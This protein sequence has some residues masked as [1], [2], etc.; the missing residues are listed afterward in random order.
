MHKHIGS[1]LVAAALAC[2]PTERSRGDVLLRKG[3]R[4]GAEALLRVTTFLNGV[5]ELIRTPSLLATATGFALFLLPLITML[6]LAVL[7]I[8]PPS[9]MAGLIAVAGV[10]TG[11]KSSGSDFVGLNDMLKNVYTRAFENN[12][13]K[14]QEVLDIIEKAEGFE[15]TEGADG[16]NV[17]MMHTFSSGGGVGAMDEDDYLYTPTSPTIKQ[18]TLAIKQL[19]ATV[20]LSGR[21]LRRVK[22]GPAAFATWAD[23][24]LPRKAQR[25]AFHKDRMALGTGTGIICRVDEA[26]PGTSDLGIDT[27][28]G[29]S[30]LEGAVNLLL[31]DD[32]LRW[33][34]NSN[35][36]S[37][38]TGAAI[39]ASVDYANNEIDIDAVPT[40]G[41]DNDYVFL[42][43]ANVNGSG[44]REMMGLEGIIDDGSN[45][46]T[47]QGL[48]R[49]T[50]P[51]LKSQI[52]DST[53]GSWGSELTEDI[54]DYADSLAWE[55]MGGKPSIILVNRSGQ[56]SFWKNLKNDRVINDPRGA[57]QGGK[58]TLNMILGDRTAKVRAA[59]KVPLSRAHLIDPSTIQRYKIGAGR[60]DDTDGSVWNRVVNSTGRKDAFFAVYVEEENL[61]SGNPGA[62]AKITG[63]ASA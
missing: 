41:A 9:A 27:A 40:S 12:V 53:S 63:L 49:T 62:N 55:R 44:T 28:F 14:E 5:G 57:F 37:P 42:G 23:E 16:K 15:V 46:A 34:P 36:S 60:W 39:V 50:Y 48:S 33:S 38:R 32:S 52:V 59:R 19:T 24:A 18:S 31:R 51:E 25:L 17:T 43:D 56:R 30:G 29:V 22:K 61:G 13:E 47:F 58:A 1:L 54:L 45:V 10:T 4:K 6:A 20:E 35:G 11:T 21:T 26:S 3:R 2:L 7:V 8:A